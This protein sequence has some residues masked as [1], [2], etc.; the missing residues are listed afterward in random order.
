MDDE[1]DHGITSRLLV[2]V[3]VRPLSQKELSKE[4]VS[5]IA[6]AIDEKVP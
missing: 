4:K 2:A 1:K 6:R 5:A 3:R